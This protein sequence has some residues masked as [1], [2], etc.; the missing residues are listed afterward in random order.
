MSAVIGK[1]TG[2]EG[3]FFAKD[4]DGNLRELSNGDNIHEGEVVIGANG[5]QLMDSI[6]VAMQDGSNTVV[7]G[8]E[9]QAFDAS[10]AKEE[11]SADETVSDPDS[12]QAILEDDI[13]GINENN[14][15]NLNNLETA[16][17]QEAAV[18]STEGGTA[19]FAELHN[20][21]QDVEADLRPREFGTDGTNGTNPIFDAPVAQAEDTS[22]DTQA[23]DTAAEDSPEDTQVEDTPEDTQVEDTP[24]DTQV[25]DTPE[26][27]QAE[28]TPEDTQVEDTPEDTQVEDTPEDTQAEDTPEDTHAEDTPASYT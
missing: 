8:N 19:N 13:V 26:D 27:T 1:V 10:L 14:L 24:E 16:A 6:T 2:L 21:S 3:K 12:L 4:S 28:D 22:E 11:F 7:Y 18:Q 25:E 20:A 17:G 23:E 5:N 15:E 9:T